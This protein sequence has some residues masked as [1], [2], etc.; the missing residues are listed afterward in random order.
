MNEIIAILSKDFG[1]FQLSYTF[2]ASSGFPSLKCIDENYVAVLRFTTPATNARVIATARQLERWHDYF[3]L[4]IDD[5][6][7]YMQT[8]P[9][10]RTSEEYGRMHVRAYNNKLYLDSGTMDTTINLAG[11]LNDFTNYIYEIWGE[12]DELEDAWWS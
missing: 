8:L 5:G 1:N 7:I 2:N 11:R 3:E 12:L 4:S 10:M 9:I 6:G